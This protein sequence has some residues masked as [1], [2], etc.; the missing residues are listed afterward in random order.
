MERGNPQERIIMSNKPYK[1]EPQI[2]FEQGMNG[3]VNYRIPSLITTKKG[4]LIAAADDRRD[5]D[6][7]NPNHINKVVRRSTDNGDTWDEINTI[8]EF[9]GYSTDGAAGCDPAMLEDKETGTIWMIYNHTPGGIGLFTSRPGTGFD[10]DGYKIII[11]NNGLKNILKEDGYLYRLDGVKTDI[12]V[13]ENGDVSREGKRL[14]GN[15]YLTT[16]PY[17]EHK[18]SFLHAVKS[19]DDGLTWSKPID[20]NFQV[21]EEWMRFI[22]AGPGVGIQ[23]QTGKYKGRLVFPIY[24]C[25]SE[26][27]YFLSC[28]VIYSDDHGVTWKRGESPNDGRVFEGREIHSQT[29]LDHRAMLT[30]SQLIQHDDG[31]LEVFMRNHADNKCVARSTSLD[32][33]ET[34]GEVWFDEALIDPTCQHSVIKYPDLGDG[35][36]RL[37]FANVAHTSKRENGVVRLSED[38]GK[39]WPYSKVLETGSFVYSC[40]TEL[41][42]NSVG[43]LYE[44]EYFEPQYDIKLWYTKF[45]LEWIK[46]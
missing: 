28:C 26:G 31:T 46:E 22:G 37:I 9:P 4:T 38:G 33:G 27:W 24:H 16:G 3:S 36:E 18:T 32:G 12:M 13:M 5:K 19:D 8:V 45:N 20:L 2:V 23:I 14:L 29:L 6:G 7:D 44:I 34:W 17:L 10:K 25:H 39:T 40:L 15:I 43:I 1:T 41:P 35:K 21:K 30:E 11:D 42:D